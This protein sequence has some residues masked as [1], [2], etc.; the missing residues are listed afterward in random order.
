MWNRGTSR[1]QVHN[2]CHLRV[3]QRT[4]KPSDCGLPE[5]CMQVSYPAIKLCQ[6]MNCVPKAKALNKHVES[7]GFPAAGMP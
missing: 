7:W 6:C 3:P 5:L 4:Q 2:S 1:G